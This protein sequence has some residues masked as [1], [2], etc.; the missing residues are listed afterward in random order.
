MT[1]VSMSNHQQVIIQTLP[2]TQTLDANTHIIPNSLHLKHQHQ[3]PQWTVSVTKYNRPDSHNQV[4]AID[5][6]LSNLP[7]TTRKLGHQN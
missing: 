5:D 7:D 6:G 2:H 3:N 4:Y 1:P